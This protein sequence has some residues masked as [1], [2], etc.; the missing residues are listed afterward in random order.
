MSPAN[1]DTSV[2]QSYNDMTKGHLCHVPAEQTFS[3]IMLHPPIE[4]VSRSIE[5]VHE[6]SQKV[7]VT[8][9]S[10][11]SCQTCLNPEPESIHT[12]LP[13][14]G[15]SLLYSRSLCTIARVPLSVF[16]FAC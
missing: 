14:H 12:E 6:C 2:A 8:D 7:P 1:E 3:S 10:F 4:A 11:C 15:I 9:P 13:S 5:A 16:V